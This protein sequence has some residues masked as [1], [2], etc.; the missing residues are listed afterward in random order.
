MDQ[1]NVTLF[2]LGAIALAS[3]LAS[4]SACR[5]ISNNDREAQPLPPDS[6][7]ATAVQQHITDPPSH[8]LTNEALHSALQR[9]YQQRAYHL[10]WETK[11]EPPLHLDALKRALKRLPG[12]GVD[13]TGFGTAQLA[14]R[15]E[16]V[17]WASPESVAALDV[18][19]SFY[20][21]R[22]ADNLLDGR[23]DADE[24]DP[25]WY[26]T[27]RSVDL[28]DQL[29]AA[30]TS[31]AVEKSL[32]E[33]APPY[34]EYRNLRKALARHRELDKNGGLSTIPSGK[35]LGVGDKSDRVPLVHE[36][37]AWQG[38][39]LRA[40]RSDSVYT[41][42]LAGAVARFQKRHALT[43]DSVLGDSTLAALNTP[44][45]ERIRTLEINMERWRWLPEEL[46]SRYVLVNIPEFKLHAYR[47]GDRVQEMS[48]VVGEHSD[49][50]ATPIFSDKIEHIVFNPYWNVPPG[51]AKNEILPKA[52]TDTSY[53][54]ER[55]YQIVENYEPDAKVLPPTSDNLERVADG[56][57]RIRQA[58][59]QNAL[60]D[61]KFMFPNQFA[62]YLHDTPAQ[63]LFDKTERAFSHGCIRLD[64]PA[65]LAEYI[66][67]DQPDWTADR[68][69]TVMQGD[70]RQRV[71]LSEPLPVYIL[72]WTARAQEDGTAQFYKDIYGYDDKLRKALD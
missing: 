32:S 15:M 49:D 24:V 33:L 13:T 55:A 54:S 47:E 12:E 57:L 72:Y 23:V 41:R 63:H 36:R 26:T 52:R 37:L 5:Y 29:D 68:I 20:F 56:E 44:I 14:Q 7:Y 39:V 62:V 59:S 40:T 70:T 9:F 42:S 18:F 67:A 66:L 27:P 6:L 25:A 58:G 35:D 64:D 3:L 51:I 19:M 2:A 8:L 69:R 61:V 17:D 11:H 48:V 16:R 34:P 21:M 71:D 50:H 31:G 43:P 65:Q 38:D 46:G 4:I 53:L 60:G 28:A 10:A 30:L 22:Y 1:S 45:Q